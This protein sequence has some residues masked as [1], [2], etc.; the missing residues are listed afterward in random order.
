MIDFE[1]IQKVV[2]LASQSELYEIEITDG[3]KRIKVVNG[4]S[5]NQVNVNTQAPALPADMANSH[6]DDSQ[7]IVATSVG[8]FV[9]MAKLG[10]TIN[11]GDMVASVEALGVL[12]PIIAD[13]AGVVSEVFLGDGDKVEYGTTLIALS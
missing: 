6:T 4:T 12:S 7:T 13:K 8:R 5:A 3:D 2:D 11:V 1:K 10:D 9:P